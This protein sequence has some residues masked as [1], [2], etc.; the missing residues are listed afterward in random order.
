MRRFLITTKKILS[1]LPRAR[2]GS[3]RFFIVLCV[4]F[5]PESYLT[6]L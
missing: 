2:D 6:V 3:E 1:D 5:V 4:V